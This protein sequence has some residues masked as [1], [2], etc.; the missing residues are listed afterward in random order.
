MCRESRTESRGGREG[1]RKGR[2]R[3][4]RGGEDEGEASPHRHTQRQDI[5]T[6]Y[7]LTGSGSASPAPVRRLHAVDQVLSPAP[8]A[9]ASTHESRRCAPRPFQSAAPPRGHGDAMDED[10]GQNTRIERLC[11]PQPSPHTAR[12]RRRHA[13][14]HLAAVCQLLSLK[15]EECCLDHRHDHHH[16]HLHPHHHR[17]LRLFL[18]KTGFCTT[19]S[20]IPPAHVLNRRPTDCPPLPTSGNMAPPSPCGSPSLHLISMSSSCP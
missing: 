4:G 20:P 19:R 18:D 3:K 9:S 12:D 16:P 10:H 15:L 7:L 1:G 14:L 11:V 8:S 6:T 13:R 5:T 17:H 2:E